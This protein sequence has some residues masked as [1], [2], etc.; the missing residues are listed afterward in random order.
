MSYQAL[1]FCPDEKTA[2]VVSQVLS[3]LE[4]HVEPCN[5]P[6]AAVKKL[7]AQHFDAIV[8]DCD[9][10]QNA[11]LLFK[12][13]RNSNSNQASLAVAVVEGQAGVAKAFRIGANLVLTKPIHVEQ[14]KGT[15]R[16]ARGLLRKGQTAKPAA[17]AATP[18]ESPAAQQP[19]PSAPSISASPFISSAVYFDACVIRAVR[20]A[21]FEH[22]A[23]NGQ[24]V[25]VRTGRGTSST[26]RCCRSYLA[27]VHAGLCALR[28][29]QIAT[30]SSRFQP[31]QSS[32]PGNRAPSLRL[33]PWRPRCAGRRKLREKL[34]SK[35]P[36]RALL[37]L[38]CPPL[39]C[40][41]LRSTKS[42]AAAAPARAKE[43]LTPGAGVSGLKP[44]V[45]APCLL[46][47]RELAEPG[48]AE[49]KISQP[50]IAKTTEPVVEGSW[51]SNPAT[52]S[53]E[54]IR[55]TSLGENAEREASGAGG[56]KKTLLLVVV[57]LA[58]VAAGYFGWTKMQPTHSQPVPQAVAPANLGTAVLPPPASP[59]ASDTQAA[60]DEV[61][62]QAPGTPVAGPSSSKPSA[63]VIAEVPGT[64]A[65]VP[66]KTPAVANDVTVIKAPG[67][68]KPEQPETLVVKNSPAAEAKAEPEP[69]E[70][71]QAPA[72]ASI[73]TDSSSNVLSG[74]VNTNAVN[75][76]KAPAQ[77]LRLSQGVSQGLLIKRVQ[78]E[79]PAQARQMR[80]GR[81]S[82]I[83]GEYLQDRQHHGGQAVER[84]RDI[85]ARRY[86]RSPAVEIQTLLSEW[87]AHR[88]SDS[89]HGELQAAV[90]HAAHV[91]VGVPP[92]QRSASSAVSAKRYHWQITPASAARPRRGRLGLRVLGHKMRPVS[93]EL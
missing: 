23:A 57:L 25:R 68:A 9:N 52:P 64:K 5:E 49:P 37:L 44:A 13:A 55:F 41:L 3:E 59:A 61:V 48:L 58:V 34:S 75:V 7:M 10:E 16:V 42:G 90:N 87:R 85:G 4:F 30:C 72:P 78:P 92:A 67:Q 82:R 45:E 1:L 24:R 21:A 69:Q 8:V 65:S 60:P 89:D 63:A 17:G 62:A 12:S 66:A 81:Q 70:P 33:S 2:R 38:Q 29:R 22:A 31:V 15:L 80:S 93:S 83:A 73:A 20:I 50:E 14:S 53:V 36:R 77:T 88:N 84:R 26:A 6:F 74:L 39:R 71:E 86:R 91:G 27:R 76:Q 43:A 32:I 11:A 19:S 79:Y 28:R 47:H 56:S 51:D 54:E 18:A 35:L 46:S 40:L